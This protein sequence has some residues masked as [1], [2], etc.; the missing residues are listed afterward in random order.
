M[1]IAVNLIGI[2]AILF[3][4]LWTL[5]ALNVLPGRV[6]AGHIQWV[7]VG[8]MLALIGLVLLVISNRPRAKAS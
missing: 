8:G 7:F 6:M 4:A 3:G 5:Q 2:F 1:K